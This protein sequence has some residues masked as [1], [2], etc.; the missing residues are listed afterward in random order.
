MTQRA[1]GRR[2]ELLGG[3]LIGAS[4]LQFGAVVLFGTFLTRDAFPITV[5]L[6]IRFLGA[7]VFLAVMLVV[8]GRPLK[9]ARG[10]G[11]PLLLLGVFGY[12]VES[13]LFFGAIRHGS[14]PAATLLFFTYPVWVSLIWVVIRHRLPERLVLV[15]LAVS[16]TGAAIVIV[17]SGGLDI[18]AEGILLAFGSSIAFSLYLIGA[19][20]VLKRSDSMTGAMWVAVSSGAALVV[21]SVIIGVWQW[22]SGWEQWGSTLGS[23]ALTAGAFFGLFAGLRRLGPV[24]AS[25]ISASEPF[26]ATVFTVVFLGEPLHPATVVGGVCILTGAVMASLVR[27]RQVTESMAP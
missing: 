3:A 17:G 16:V 6:G 14:A 4:A 1:A 25:V 7:A 18:S 8:L 2:A 24:R 9:A 26:W 10:E 12:A 11:V 13:G 23:S 19:D 15:S 27:S 22:P 21:L 20:R 5:F